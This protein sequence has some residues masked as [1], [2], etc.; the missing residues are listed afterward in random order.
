MTFAEHNRYG[1]SQAHDRSF[2]SSPPSPSDRDAPEEGE[3]PEATVLASDTRNLECDA[4]LAAS[5]GPPEGSRAPQ[6]LPR[7]ALVGRYVV[8]ARLGAGAMG[9]VYAAYDPE[10]DRKIAIK[11]LHPQR[12]DGARA[13]EGQHRLLREAQAMAK[14]AHPNVITVHDVGVHDGRVYVAME[15]VEGTTLAEWLD[16]PHHWREA[17]HVLVLAGRGL[18]AAHAKGLVHRDFK[19][20]NVMVGTDGR[21]RV[22]DFG[23]ARPSGSMEPTVAVSEASPI[24]PN[25]NALGSALTR[26]G[27]IVGTPAYMA[28]EQWH[29]GEV[30]PAADQ[31]AWA[32]SL[33]E[34]LYGQRPFSA[35][36]LAALAFAV[37]QGRIQTPPARRKV[38]GW[39][40]RILRRAL[41][42]DPQQRYPSM[43]AVLAQVAR[44]KARARTRKG[45]ALVAGLMLAGSGVHAAKRYERARRVA[46]CQAEGTSIASIW[47]DETRQAVR[48]G[49]H[50]THLPYAQQT[51]ERTLPWLDRYAETWSRARTQACLATHVDETWDRDTLERSMWCLDSRRFAFATLVTELTEPDEATAQQAVM[52]AAGMSPIS[53]CLD[54]ALLSHHPDPPDDPAA[55]HA[56]QRRISK[57]WIQELSGEYTEALDTVRDA[58]AR[59]EALGYVPLIAHARMREGELLDDIGEYN[60][61]RRALEDAY[62]RSMSAGALGTAADAASALLYTTGSGQARYRE[63]YTWGR[64]AEVALT[65]LGAGEDTLRHAALLENRASVL[66]EEGKLKQAISLELRSLR[67]QEKILGPDHPSVGRA[68]TNLAT[69][70]RALGEYGAARELSERAVRILRDS[71]GPRHPDVARAMLTL[72][73]IRR[74]QGDLEDA[75]AIYSRA[76]RTL[77]SAL[78]PGNPQI[79][80]ALNNLAIVHRNAGEFERAVELYERALAILEDSSG[81]RHPHVAQVLNNLARAHAALGHT[82]EAEA[83]YRRALAIWEEALGPEHGALAWSL[84][85]LAELALTK[86]R[87]AQALPLA[88]RALRLRQSTD[89]APASLADIQ[90]ILAQALWEAPAGAG[91]DHDQ[92]RSLAEQARR[93]F[94]NTPGREQ[95]LEAVERWLAA[96]PPTP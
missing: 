75:K 14:L 29:G 83:L 11:L 5:S 90:F 8:L 49:L 9:V 64:H 88:R 53:P 84:R 28:P 74:A 76:I 26:V 52:S 78:D 33:W 96:H 71:L 72:A 34:A 1:G 80:Q 66:G 3:E 58:L 15:F 20:D 62:F 69:H 25:T 37:S 7:G 23:L 82:Q 17:L 94:M 36:N 56:V 6:E 86:G 38:P 51:A 65:L 39:L 31:F 63:A 12:G 92:A 42:P 60:D 77:E 50:A 40:Q 81:P 18:A 70:D 13:S 19:P 79:A 87:P 47:N 22:M 91:R 46:A 54:A 10:L 2:M 95:D 59:S 89:S 4:T 48:E 16:R 61:A 55:V 45:A 67:I 57:A 68:L 44:G 41:S 43:D 73:A 21:V 93:A 32:V 24:G 27:A 30:G 85:G 35:D